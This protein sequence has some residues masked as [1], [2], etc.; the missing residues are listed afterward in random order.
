[1]KVPYTVSVQLVW[2]K[3]QKRVESKRNPMIGGKAGSDGDSVDV[4]DFQGEVLSM[5]SSL[6]RDKNAT[7]KFSEKMSAVVIKIAKG[8]K[9][10]SVG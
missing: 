1:M 10:K 4:A 6:Y 9:T 8:E 2:K 3:D 5:I 7:N